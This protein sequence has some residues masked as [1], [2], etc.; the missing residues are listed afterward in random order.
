MSY[1]DPPK[2]CTNIFVEVRFFILN[3]IGGLCFA[4]PKSDTNIVVELND[5]IISNLIC[6]LCNTTLKM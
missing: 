5:I 3:L 1:A 6:G 4:N 2:V